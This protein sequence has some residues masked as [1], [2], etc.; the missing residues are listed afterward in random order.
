VREGVG[1]KWTGESVVVRIKVKRGKEESK[2]RQ[3]RDWEE[4][5]VE[6]V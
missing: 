4:D 2:E 5:S 1:G 6:K 3:E